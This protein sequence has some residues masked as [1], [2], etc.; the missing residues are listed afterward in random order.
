MRELDPMVPNGRDD[1]GPLA[2]DPSPQRRKNP[3]DQKQ[4][5]SAGSQKHLVESCGALYVVDRYF[6]KERR[7]V[8]HT[9]RYVRDCDDPKVVDFKV[10]KLDE[11]RMLYLEA[12]VSHLTKCQSDHCPILLEL[13]PCSN[14]RLSRPFR[15]QSF[16]L[17]DASLP[18]LV[19]NAW[20]NQL[21]LAKATS[22]FTRE[23]QVWNREKFGN[24]FARKKRLWA[25]LNGVH[26]A[27]VSSA[28]AFLVNLEKQLQE[29]LNSVLNQEE[30]L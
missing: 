22:R 16:W 10:Y 7:R 5:P 8:E 23:V 30:E 29:D 11:K 2:G 28:N 19:R 15:F 12:Q 24:I 18:D 4:C 25:R 21:N 26:K 6:N 27:M 9:S 20:A 1:E 14:T 3:R 17:I 13:Q